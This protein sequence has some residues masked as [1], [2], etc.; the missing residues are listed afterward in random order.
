MIR[1]LLPS[2]A[3]SALLFAAWLL[4]QQ[5]LAPGALLM[6]ALLAVGVP[7]LTRS[8]RPRH[9]RVYRPLPALRLLG[10]VL[11]DVVASN[12][13][14][15][16]VIVGRSPERIH[17]HFLRVP[18]QVRDP[19]ALAGLAVILSLAPGTAWAELSADGSEL[20]VH[21]FDVEDPAQMVALIRERYERP[22]KEIFEP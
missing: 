9:G 18:L 2:P 4:L 1:R 6:A 10:V 16:R 3:L 17:S 20:L 12:L 22:L 5:S 19:Y 7:L 14:V 13:H 11:H 8:L 21:A 15:A